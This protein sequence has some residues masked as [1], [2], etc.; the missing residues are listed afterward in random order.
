MP[1]RTKNLRLQLQFIVQVG[2]GKMKRVEGLRF[3]PETTVAMVRLMNVTNS[4]R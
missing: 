1:K 3:M 2:T 4:E